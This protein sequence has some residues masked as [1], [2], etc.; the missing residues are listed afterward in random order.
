MVEL[1]KFYTRP[2]VALWLKGRTFR[3]FGPTLPDRK[4]EPSAGAGAFLEDRDGL[5]AFD[6]K[7]DTFRAMQL[8]DSV[9]PW[10]VE[11]MAYVMADWPIKELLA[12]GNPPFGKRGNLAAKFINTYLEVG[13]LV[14]FVLPIV[15]RKWA[16]QKQVTPNARLVSDWDLPP[17]AFETPE[18]KPYALDCC[19]QIW[20]VRETDNRFDDLR[21][22]RPV[23]T[24]SDFEVWTATGPN[25]AG[26][27]R[28]FDFATFCQGGGRYDEKF[29]QDYRP[30]NVRRHMLFKAHTPKALA[31]LMRLDFSELSNGWAPVRGFGSAEV[32]QAYNQS[33]SLSSLTALPAS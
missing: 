24:H 30:A 25:H 4:L 7:P 31:V 20:S 12:I 27:L 15:F 33:S 2:E 11:M 9:H 5:V 16:G 8:D 21:L 26:W 28:Q 18:G 22:S 6:L 10:V 19:F 13:G 29:T 32:V 23:R 17:D 1:D 14:A 3:M